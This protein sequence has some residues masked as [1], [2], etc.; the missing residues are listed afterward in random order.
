MLSASEPHYVRC[1]KPNGEKTPETLKSTPVLEQ[2][3]NAGMMETIRIRQKGFATRSL[4][5]EFFAQYSPLLPRCRNL[6][7]LVTQLS[8]MLTVGDDSWQVG[9]SK[10]FLRATM[11]DKLDR[12]LRVRFTQSARR[13]QAFWRHEVCKRAALRIQKIMRR[14]LVSVKFQRI[15]SFA[16]MNQSMLRMYV[17]CSMLFLP[18]FPFVFDGICVSLSL[19]LLLSTCIL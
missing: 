13:I 1:I 15:R 4:H 3:K 2:L 16:I 9:K 10:V 6:T 18:S 12:L 17:F 11:S 14:F 5:T 8:T 7:E 19:N